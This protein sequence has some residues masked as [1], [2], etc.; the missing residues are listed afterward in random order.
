MLDQRIEDILE[1]ITD[2]FA[3]VDRE[4]RYTYINDRA[5]RRIQ[6]LKGEELTREDIL[7]ENAWELIPELVGSVFYDKYHEAMREHRG[8]QSTSGM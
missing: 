6:T 4:R 3:A 2:E 8:S 1:S 7:G 5:L